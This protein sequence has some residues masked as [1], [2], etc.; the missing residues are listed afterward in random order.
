MLD[1]AP[2]AMN[3][4]VTAVACRVTD[5]SSPGRARLRTFDD[6]ADERDEPSARAGDFAAERRDRLCLTHSLAERPAVGR[7]TRTAGVL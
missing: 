1:R 6:V 3:T 4:A 2:L 5:A 7:A